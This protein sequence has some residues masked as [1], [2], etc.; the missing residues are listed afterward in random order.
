M[1]GCRFPKDWLQSWL[2]GEAGKRAAQT[3]DHLEHCR[4]CAHM[5]D[6]WRRTGDQLRSLVDEG[7]GDIEPLVGLQRIRE[8]VLEAERRSLMGRLRWWW[9]EVWLFH[10][11]AL[12]GLAVAAALGA[13]AAPG[14]IY[15]LAQ[16]SGQS[17]PLSGPA[18][19][20]E[21]LEVGDN[22]TAVVWGSSEEGMTTIIWVEPGAN[23]HHE[24][25]F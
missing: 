3:R 16:I 7:L 10:R 17:G 21:S 8:R 15:V 6:S 2:D 23:A 20:V 12:A 11:K 5:V 14:V 13:L 4:E 19:V 1:S 9:E 25:T 22:S 18:V 24:E